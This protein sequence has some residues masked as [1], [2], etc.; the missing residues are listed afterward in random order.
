M[1]AKNIAKDFLGCE[2][3]RNKRHASLYT[4]IMQRALGVKTDVLI[5]HHLCFEMDKDI[6][7]EN[8]IPAADTLLFDHDVMGAVFGDKAIE[9][10]MHLARTPTES[11]DE[12]LNDYVS[13]V[14]TVNQV[15]PVSGFEQ[16]VGRG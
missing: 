4:V 1:E 2:N 7:T 5:G 11:R 10:M 16:E 15:Y 13:C 6:N 12:V 9:V 8:E 14:D 3:A